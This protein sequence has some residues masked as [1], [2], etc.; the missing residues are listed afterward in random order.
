MI[1]QVD[2]ECAKSKSPFRHQLTGN[3]IRMSTDVFTNQNLVASSK[4]HVLLHSNVKDPAIPNRKKLRVYR[5]LKTNQ[6]VQNLPRTEPHE[7][8]AIEQELS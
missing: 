3:V 8:T 6:N 1:V 7:S 2:V 5:T 4:I